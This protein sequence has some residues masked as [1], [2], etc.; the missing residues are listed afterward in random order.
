[1]NGFGPTAANGFDPA[2]V[3]ASLPTASA[4]ANGFGPGVGGY[5]PDNADY[6]TD[7][8]GYGQLPPF[9]GG[10]TGG[11]PVY[12]GQPGTV[13]QYATGPS[14]RR[15]TDPSASSPGRA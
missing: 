11:L 10:Q 4:R 13:G 2:S 6:V 1:M 7:P 9:A 5:Q 12:P 15:S 3:T 14:A 8:S